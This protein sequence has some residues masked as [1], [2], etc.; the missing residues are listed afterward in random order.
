MAHA[1]QSLANVRDCVRGCLRVALTGKAL[2]RR[3]MRRGR[4][5]ATS[6]AYDVLSTKRTPKGSE[7]GILHGIDEW[8]FHQTPDGWVWRYRDSE[9][10]EEKQSPVAFSSIVDCIDDAA[11][12]GYFEPRPT[13]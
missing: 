4:Q 11:R 12:A 7:E 1:S 10:G 5:T 8:T 13:G 6:F 3:A 2:H 9:T